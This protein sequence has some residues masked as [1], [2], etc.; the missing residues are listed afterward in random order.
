M[1]GIA[2]VHERSGTAAEAAALERAMGRLAHRGPDGSDVA[3]LGHVALGHLHFWTLPEEVGELQPLALPGT[4]FTIAFDGRLDNRDELLTALEI[5]REEGR[6]FSD[7]AIALR[8][9][10]RWREDCLPRFLG[11]FALVVHDARSGDLFCARDPL[12]DRTLFWS[13]RGTRTLVAS[14]PWAVTAADRP[15]EN[16]D[17]IAAAHHF[18]FEIPADGRTLFADVRE[19]LPGRYL[20]IGGTGERTVRY[21]EPDL[22][23]RLR[24]R[25]DE[26]YAEGFRALLTESVRCRLRGSTPVGVLM[27]GGLDSGSVACLA[28]AERP[29]E[30]LT[31]IS[32]VFD[33]LTECDER[34]YIAEIEKQWGIRSLQIPCDGLWP[35]RGWPDAWPK[36]RNEP[37]GN[38]Y[39]LLKE[40]AYGRAREEGLRVLLTGASGDALYR[41]GPDWFADL[42]AEGQLGEAGREAWGVVRA[43]GVR[44]TLRSTFVRRLARRCVDRLP[45]GRRLRRA[46]S[47][48]AWLTPFA[49]GQLREARD[50]RLPD[51]ACEEGLV[52][53]YAAWSA[54]AEAPNAARHALE[55][56]DPYRDRRLIELVLAL[57][58]HQLFRRGRYKHV[59]RNTM[60]GILPEAIR[61]RTS[62]SPLHALLNRGLEREQKVLDRCFDQTGGAWRRFVRAEWLAERWRR[63]VGAAE[64]GPQ[65]MVAWRCVAFEEWF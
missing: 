59:L 49:A 13:R 55:L 11:E 65:A 33:E 28:A 53:L 10:A 58:A 31:T 41:R 39:R 30:R 50:G 56:R 3:R 12:G 29:S 40:A 34:P 1:S 4:P 20:A 52:G 38:P 63:P 8:A 22:A 24:G 43:I 64:D 16:L 37:E 51:P 21:W 25:S 5:D 14:E 47:P 27:S 61:A 54:S 35:L 62:P 44:E 57:P 18:A 45:G 48:P 9:F 46:W 60:P 19:L 42:L 23:R 7:A 36:V 15:G 17:E 6:R 2:A 32:Y 26:E